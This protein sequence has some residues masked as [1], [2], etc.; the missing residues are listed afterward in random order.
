MS[1]EID[2]IEIPRIQEYLQRTFGHNGIALK[3]RDK[4]KDSVE[5]ILNGEFIAVLYKDDEEGEIS[6]NLNMTILNEDL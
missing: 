1:A 4:V 3:V 2:P 6:Y 5:V